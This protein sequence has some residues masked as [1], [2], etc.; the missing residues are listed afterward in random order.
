MWVIF[1]KIRIS[2]HNKIPNYTSRLKHGK[3][4]FNNMKQ[5]NSQFS[6]KNLYASDSLKS[7]RRTSR[8]SQV[9][10]AHAGC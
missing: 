1:D 7:N 5:K 2:K 4:K 9:K 3:S 6:I 8:L 10:E